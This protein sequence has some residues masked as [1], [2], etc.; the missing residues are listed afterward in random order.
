M[1]I[2]EQVSKRFRS[3]EGKIV[4]EGQQQ[5]TGTMVKILKDVTVVMYQCAK[6]HQHKIPKLEKAFI[7]ICPLPHYIGANVRPK[8]F[9]HRATNRSGTFTSEKSGD[10]S[11]ITGDEVNSSSRQGGLEIC[12]SVPPK[13]V[14]ASFTDIFSRD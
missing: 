13:N 10:Q 1:E 5:L 6:I 2:L 4:K 9:T 3:K 7:S 12:A 14:G 11:L 8:I